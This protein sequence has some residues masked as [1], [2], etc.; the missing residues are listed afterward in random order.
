MSHDNQ[1][2]FEQSKTRQF[3]L[4]SSI[5]LKTSHLMNSIDLMEILQ[6]T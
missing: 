2:S 5:E 1:K 6:A 4:E 3:N